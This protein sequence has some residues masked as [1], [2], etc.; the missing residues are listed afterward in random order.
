MDMLGGGVF[1]GEIGGVSSVAV[2]YAIGS[3]S[4]VMN[5]HDRVEGVEASDTTL[6]LGA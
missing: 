1:G 6:Q 5:R 3:Y 4:V 2:G